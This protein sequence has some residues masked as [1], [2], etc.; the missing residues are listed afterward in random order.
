MMLSVI[1]TLDLRLTPLEMSVIGGPSVGKGR[2]PY[3]R[4]TR[5]WTADVLVVRELDLTTTNGSGKR[6]VPSLRSGDRIA[7]RPPVP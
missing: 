2:L 5:G 3:S 1:T 7:A 4:L 6:F